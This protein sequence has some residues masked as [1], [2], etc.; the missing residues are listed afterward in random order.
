MYAIIG[1]KNAI[2]VLRLRDPIL[3][4]VGVKRVGADG[5][6]DRLGARDSPR[7]LNWEPDLGE[8]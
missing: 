7:I 6:I 3:N 2:W 8:V 1:R 4:S 5:L